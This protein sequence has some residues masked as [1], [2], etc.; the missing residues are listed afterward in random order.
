MLRSTK[1]SSNFYKRT[2]FSSALVKPSN[3]RNSKLLLTKEFECVNW[4]V[5][6]FALNRAVLC[7]SH[8]QHIRTWCRQLFLHV[9]EKRVCCYASKHVESI[10]HEGQSIRSQLFRIQMF[11]FFFCGG[12][13]CY[14]FFLR[15]VPKLKAITKLDYSSTAEERARAD[16]MFIQLFGLYGRLSNSNPE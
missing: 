12:G 10:G 1:A 5:D 4:D 11:S 9:V 16:L 2:L 15:S 13:G 3:V 14:W 6:C 7:A 8:I